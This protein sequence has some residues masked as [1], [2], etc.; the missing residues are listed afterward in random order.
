MPCPGC[1]LSKVKFKWRLFDDAALAWTDSA[2]FFQCL[3]CG[4]KFS[5]L[6]GAVGELYTDSYYIFQEHREK[7][8]QSFAQ[9]CCEWLGALYPINGKMLLDA[10]CGR[11]YFCEAAKQAG[12]DVV[13]VEPSKQVA[14]QVQKRTGIPV[15]PGFLEDA[16]IF[17]RQFDVLTMWDVLEHSLQPMIMLS[18]ASSLLKPKGILAIS[19]PNVSSIFFHFAGPFWKGYNQYHISH[20]SIKTIKEMLNRANFEVLALETYDN[21]IF[22]KEGFYR[23]GIMDRLKAVAARNSFLR[24]KLLK[25]RAGL[26]PELFSTGH[27]DY[28]FSSNNFSLRHLA[29][30]LIKRFKLGDQIRVLARKK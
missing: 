12:A 14:L 22:S 24:Q 15:I 16:V 5:F 19:V 17:D 6:S 11:G 26:K 25:R 20:F 30:L 29:D 27:N 1:G 7:A 13:G 2:R 8:D 23:L 28:V 18:K 3:N 21:G 9:H 10:G 4:L